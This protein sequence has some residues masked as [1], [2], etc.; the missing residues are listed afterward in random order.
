MKLCTKLISFFICQQIRTW[1]LQVSCIVTTQ[2]SV[3]V[4]KAMRVWHETRGRV[5]P[6]VSRLVFAPSMCA[7]GSVC[8]QV[9]EKWWFIRSCILFV[10]RTGFDASK[11]FS[12][13]FVPSVCVVIWERAFLLQTF[14]REDL[15]QDHVWTVTLQQVVEVFR[16]FTE[17]KVYHSENTPL[18]VEVSTSQS[19]DCAIKVVKVYTA[20][21]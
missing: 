17:V 14:S 20:P 11:A 10:N 6:A 9:G 21:N 15:K 2:D 8:Q 3:S 1:F 13:P 18:Q 4:K 16:S 12:P 7:S 19:I 5:D